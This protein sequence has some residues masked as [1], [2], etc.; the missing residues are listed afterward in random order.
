MNLKE[1]L[2]NNN[3]ETYDE[4]ADHDSVSRNGF[5]G[6]GR[7][8]RSG[9][10]AISVP[11]VTQDVIR[12]FRDFGGAMKKALLILI[13]VY[14]LRVV[15][16]CGSASVSGMTQSS[17]TH[18]SVT[19]T[20]NAVSGTSFKITVTALDASNNAV[21]S[22][23][24]TVSFTSSDPKAVL[25]NSANLTD[26]TGNFFAT[27]VTAG[28]QTIT[29][30]DGASITGTSNPIAVALP[31][32][33]F[34]VAAPSNATAGI[35]FNLTVTARDASNNTVTAYGGTVH[36]S[37][38]DA[39]GVL[40]A[41][42]PLVNGTATFSATL[43][44][45]GNQTVTA[46]DTSTASI[47]GTS[48]AINVGTSAPTH[49]S[50][51]APIF[52]FPGSAFS[53]TVS[54]VDA[55]DNV[56]PTYSGTAHFTSSD[57]LGSLPANSALS[58]GSGNFSAT[59]NTLGSQSITATDTVSGS[60]NGTSNSINVSPLKITSGSPPNGTVGQDYGPTNSCLPTGFVLSA[61]G[62][63]AKFYSWTAASLPP[64]LK[65]GSFLPSPAGPDCRPGGSAAWMIYGAPT[66]AGTFNNVAITVQFGTVTATK[67][68]AITIAA[69]ATA[70]DKHAEAVSGVAPST[71]HHHYKLIDVG[72]FGGP[73]SY[74]NTL[75]VTDGFGFSTAFYSN[76]QVR[77]GKGV[78]VGFA[79]TSAPD[80]FPA[81][82]YV[83]ECSVA[84]AFQWRNGV[85]S[86]LGALP[87]GASSAAF[88]I[89][90]KGWVAGNSQNGGTDPAFPGLPEIRAVLWEDGKIKDLGTLGGSSSFAEAMND[91]GQI[92]G[93]A[94]N[95]VSDPFSYYY[96]FL[97]TFPN[98]FPNGTQTRAFLWDEKEGMQD[99]GTLGGPDA[100]PSLINQR[101]QVAGFSY[102][103]STPDPNI[104][105][106]P[107]HPFLWEKGKGMQDL[108]SFGGAATASV[109]GLNERGEVVGGLDLPGDQV[110]NPFLWD[111]EKL[112]DLATPP[113]VG[114][115]NGE[116]NWIN[117]AGEVVGIASLPTQCPGSQSDVVHGFL[118]RN[119][120][121][122][123]LG[124]VA[125]TSLG[126]A[127]F[128]NS[129]TQVVGGSWACD[130]SVFDAFLWENG[131]IVDL[132]T[133]VS[134]GSE[135][136]LYWA[137]YI[138][139]EGIIGAFGSLPN[140][141]SHAVLLIPC[142]ENHPNIEGC[143]YS[144]FDA[145]RRSFD[146]DEQSKPDAKL[147][148]SADAMRRLLRCA[149][150][151]AMPLSRRS[152]VPPQQ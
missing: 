53:F 131:S 109:N 94:L 55:A 24:G 105:L 142:D 95:E 29:A 27:L 6:F 149:G 71:A 28:A 14:C 91:R 7:C 139:D 133:L 123:D 62:G 43:K 54:A 70:A 19:A 40:P 98:L 51:S 77:N 69:A 102:I 4:V 49:F 122:T 34:S 61:S 83:P 132:N 138:D 124:S 23:S 92:T 48:S 41:N 58:N 9:S 141:D 89:N 116:A 144:L 118:W 36:F 145:A 8:D 31:V 13:S 106:P 15:S 136:S 72:T 107:F 2:A 114:T 103:N 66:Q 1:D 10:A 121:V 57:P 130:N 39:Q 108:G 96:V 74:F 25:P 90:A 22:F 143:D 112:I 26:G 148:L 44:T 68:Y 78:F 80:P 140:G 20:N 75:L 30:Q 86:D 125:G 126:R 73:S 32:A 59:L 97:Y 5:R 82:C 129:P 11:L 50:V 151:R 127:D 120:T 52:A 63:V 101:G 18:F 79:D 152:A 65:I 85:T 21:A 60:I 3:R 64:G 42:A 111:G 137:P 150:L 115:G 134:S 93:L 117:E 135:L 113:F 45:L 88:W 47:G 67:V 119:G 147:A 17:V 128:V 46:T 16:G 33:H 87:G 35:A 81:F 76:A 100:L 38:S 56:A 104:G 99:L 84:H 37:S 110:N 12:D 146:G